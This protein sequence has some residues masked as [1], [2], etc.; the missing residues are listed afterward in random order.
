MAPPTPSWVELYR[1]CSMHDAQSLVLTLLAM[2]FDA[3]CEQ[4][5]DADDA[6]HNRE[7]LYIIETDARDVAALRGVI[8]QILDEQTAFDRAWEE[9]H[10]ARAISA[11]VALLL[12][13]LPLLA[14]LLGMLLQSAV[15][16][17]QQRERTNPL[18]PD[19]LLPV[20]MVA[21]AAAR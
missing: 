8:D 20:P 9:A 10:A 12:T 21:V 18:R 7:C 16:A 17:H 1:T 4:L 2:E 6:P 19:L 11:V 15:A 3:R 5:P 14:M 13:L